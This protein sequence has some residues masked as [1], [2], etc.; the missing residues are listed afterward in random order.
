MGRISKVHTHDIFSHIYQCVVKDDALVLSK[1]HIYMYFYTSY[2][3]HI[4]V[5]VHIKVAGS[6]KC[7]CKCR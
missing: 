1:L 6:A 2:I 7:K 5:F 3:T 4:H